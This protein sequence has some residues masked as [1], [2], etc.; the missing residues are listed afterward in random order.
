[1]ISGKLSGLLSGQVLANPTGTTKP[2]GRR[3]GQ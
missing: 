3:D 2:V 1:M